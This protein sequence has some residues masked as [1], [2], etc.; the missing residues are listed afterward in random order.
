MTQIHISIRKPRTGGLDP[1]TGLMRFRPVR[2]HFDADKNLVIAA[3]FD[4]DLSETGELTVDLLPTTSA[5]VWQ[6]I[7]LA[8]TP[9]A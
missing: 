5:F 7:E 6:V 1:V 4:A 9:Q 2:R 8:D 3:S